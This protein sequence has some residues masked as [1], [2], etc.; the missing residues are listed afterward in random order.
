MKKLL[1]LPFFMLVS[2]GFCQE[3]EGINNEDLILP[4]AS[5]P[6]LQTSYLKEELTVRKITLKT[7]VTL[8]YVEKGA[9]NGTP[10]IF[11]HGLS[12]SWHSFE[13]VFDYLPSS[14][15]GFA[16]TQRG[17]GDSEKPAD[18][19]APKDFA[20]DVA[21]FI[22]QKELKKAVV[23]G[24]S[25]G[26]VHA[27][28]FVLSYPKLAQAVVI[29]DSDPSFIDN[30]GMPEFYHD[31]SKLEGVISWQF[32]DGFQKATLAK[33][34]DS[35]FYRV[36]VEEGVKMP[37]SVFKAVLKGLL[38][39]DFVPQLKNIHCPA[40]ILWGDKDAFC[41][42]KGQDLMANNIK[43][44]KL[45]IYEGVG[46]ALHW[47]EPERFVKDLLKFIHSAQPDRHETNTKK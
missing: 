36:I 23:V 47:E 34:I 39:V 42:R 30:P 1:S 17:H 3:P 14:I 27:Q 15:R 7:G 26:G 9:A 4:A 19:Y 40:L 38:Q 12:D 5:Q 22:Q 21:A 46:H 2:S 16:L 6:S 32:M 35:A 10:V 43:N 45:V 33:P 44:A 8:D 24:H 18:G 28:Q 20:A 13:K 37:V 31:V 29:I 25:M 11:L 41:I